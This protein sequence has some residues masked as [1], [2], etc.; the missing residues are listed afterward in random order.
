VVFFGRRFILSKPTFLTQFLGRKSLSIVLVSALLL[1]FTA[2][3]F[4]QSQEN[5]AVS[6][7]EA[8]RRIV[9]SY[10]QAGKGQ[11][12]K[13]YYEQALKTFVMAQGYQEI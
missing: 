12:D 13:G 10:F 4:A 1:V 5:G 6:R 11:Y 7:Q 3:E 9:E 2:S 8:F